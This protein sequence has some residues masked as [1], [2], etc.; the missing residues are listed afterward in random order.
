[1]II[2]AIAAAIRAPPFLSVDAIRT[3]PARAYMMADSA[4]AAFR[5][6]SIGS[7]ASMIIAGTIATTAA[8]IPKNPANPALFL[9]AILPARPIITMNENIAVPPVT[10]V[11]KL[12]LD[13]ISIDGMSN[14]IATLIAIRPPR[15]FILLLASAPAATIIPMNAINE[16]ADLRRFFHG[17]PASILAEI[18]ISNSEPPIA[19][20]AIPNDVSFFSSTL[21]LV[22]ILSVAIRA[23][24]IPA[25]IAIDVLSRF[26]GILDMTN[27]EPAINDIEM[28]IV[29]KACIFRLF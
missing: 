8:D 9:P 28:A 16:A 24:N 6:F 10:R 7:I 22:S 14:P 12:I 23:A 17:I 29:L 11:S 2:A 21:S 25:I 27:N 18:L 13:I 19:P 20:N 26:I 1:M 15:S 3:A 5:D 4:S